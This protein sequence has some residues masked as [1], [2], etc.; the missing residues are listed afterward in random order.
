M[1]KFEDHELIILE[2][3]GWASLCG[4]QDVHWSSPLCRNLRRGLGLYRYNAIY[5]QG[6][7]RSAC[8]KCQFTKLAGGQLITQGIVYL[9]MPCTRDTLMLNLLQ[10]STSSRFKGEYR[11]LDAHVRQ[12]GS[13]KFYQKISWYRSAAS[14][15]E[16]G[17]VP[18]GAVSAGDVMIDGNAIGDVGNIVL[19]DRKVR[20]K[21]VSL[22]WLSRSIVRKK[23]HFQ[24]QGSYSVVYVKKEPWHPRESTDLINKTV[25]DYLSSG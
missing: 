8:G 18:A 22:S 10:Q 23:N 2:T 14:C 12:H 1:S 20:T 24:S 21:T 15:H 11:G 25:E 7:S 17:L 4:A 5:C 16:N 19:R 9:A 6:S 3:V 13:R